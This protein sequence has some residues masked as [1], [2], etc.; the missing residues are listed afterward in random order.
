MALFSNNVKEGILGN[1]STRMLRRAWAR[2]ERRRGGERERGREG[3]GGGGG[4][5][6][7]EYSSHAGYEPAWQSE[8]QEVSLVRYIRTR[9][10]RIRT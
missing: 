10:V 9:G 1:L 6:G 4:G 8:V 7:L 5:G 2:G 3:R